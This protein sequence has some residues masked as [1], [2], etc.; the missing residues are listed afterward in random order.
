[1]RSPLHE[2]EHNI[3]ANYTVIHRHNIVIIEPVPQ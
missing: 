1:M 3:V 2:S